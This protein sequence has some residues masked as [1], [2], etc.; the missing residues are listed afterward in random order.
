M[1]KMYIIKRIIS[2]FLKEATL[3]VYETVAAQVI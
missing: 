1:D 2:V 3:E